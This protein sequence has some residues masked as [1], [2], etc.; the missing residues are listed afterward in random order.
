MGFRLPFFPLYAA[1]T[2]ADG[3]FQGWTLEE[4]GAWIT[5]LCYAW[6]DGDL[7]AAQTTLARLLGIGPGD[8]AR[9]WSAIGD[10][11]TEAPGAPGR[12]VCPRLE[13]ERDKALQLGR[14]RAE[15][16]EKGAKARWNKGKRAHGKRMPLPKPPHEVANAVPVANGCPLPSPSQ[17]PSP[18]T[19]ATPP[20]GIPTK[21]QHLAAQ[22]P[23]AQAVLDSLA[24]AEWALVH[25]GPERRAALE[26]AIDGAGHR[27]AFD[28]VRADLEERARR[29]QEIPGSIGFYLPDLVAL[30]KR[31]D[32]PPAR[33]P[34]PILDLAWLDEGPEDRRQVLRAAWEAKRAEIE[35][36]FRPDA[37]PRALAGAAEML[38]QEYAP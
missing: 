38:R 2:L 10:R 16:G 9:T 8:M 12:I 29:K 13:E 34:A 33:P 20:P 18:P 6:N 26:Q 23:K 7:P 36:S 17:P 30:A 21:A 28:L 22:A 32:D 14:I 3:R 37:V 1:E 31:R 15:A 27:A 5:L 24:A 19:A 25:A 11:F 4:R 35:S